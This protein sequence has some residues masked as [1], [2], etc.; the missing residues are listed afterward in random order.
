M[1]THVHTGTHHNMHEHIHTTCYHIIYILPHACTH[2]HAYKACRTGYAHMHTPILTSKNTHIHVHKY[3][4][5]MHVHT[6]TCT[7]THTFRLVYTHLHIPYICF[8]IDTIS[9]L[10]LVHFLGFMLKKSAQSPCRCRALSAL[11]S[12]PV[13]ALLWSLRLGAQR[14][15][16][17]PPPCLDEEP[18]QVKKGH[19]GSRARRTQTSD[20]SRGSPSQQ[21]VS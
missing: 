20:P 8:H 3:L 12:V 6:Y 13:H 10:C 14:A 4:H 17:W 9:T 2:I 15:Q 1:C 18:V 7:C 21:L 19:V 16:L 5:V 11:Q